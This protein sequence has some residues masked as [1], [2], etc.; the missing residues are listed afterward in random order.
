MNFSLRVPSSGG[1]LV[2]FAAAPR[3]TAVAICRFASSHFF[4]RDCHHFLG[5]IAKIFKGVFLVRHLHLP[6]IPSSRLKNP[7]NEIERSALATPPVNP[8]FVCV[9]LVHRADDSL[10]LTPRLPDLGCSH[11]DKRVMLLYCFHIFALLS[12]D[13]LLRPLLSL[14]FVVTERDYDYYGKS[15]DHHGCRLPRDL[16]AHRVNS[17]SAC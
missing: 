7:I 17:N 5:E 12:C 16:R 11:A 14:G 15:D 9:A 6:S 3:L 13:L 10:R 4:L 1:N 2:G 8:F